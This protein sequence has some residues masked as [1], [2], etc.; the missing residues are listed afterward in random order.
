MAGKGVVL[1]DETEVAPDVYLTAR[2]VTELM[3]LIN[4]VAGQNGT[5]PRHAMSGMAIYAELYSDPPSYGVDV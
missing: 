5:S 2:Q 1:I 4:R 3:D